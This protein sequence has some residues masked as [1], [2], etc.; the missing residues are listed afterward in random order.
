M[1]LLCRHRE[2]YMVKCGNLSYCLCYPINNVVTL[3]SFF[4]PKF[5]KFCFSTLLTLVQGMVFGTCGLGS[6]C[7]PLTGG[8][9]LTVWATPGSH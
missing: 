5:L 6:H 2:F 3:F 8:A 7:I 4:F 1:M 9:R